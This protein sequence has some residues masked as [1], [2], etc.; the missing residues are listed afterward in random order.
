[1]TDTKVMVNAE[2]A[3][4][5]V[6]ENSVAPVAKKKTSSIARLGALCGV[7]AVAAC[8]ALPVS[9]TGEESST[10]ATIATTMSSSFTNVSDQ[11]GQYAIAVLPAGLG[12]FAITFCVR[13]G[14]GFFRT[15]AR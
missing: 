10:N 9:A 6:V 15:V 13:K 12:V 7:L 8:M 2:V 4:P 5:D 1:M 11:L 14:M 3:E